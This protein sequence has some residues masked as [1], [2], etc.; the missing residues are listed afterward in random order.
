MCKGLINSSEI[1]QGCY[2][3]C[4]YGCW[5][6]PRLLIIWYRG[7]FLGS[8]KL[9]RDVDHKLPSSVKVKK[10]GDYSTPFYTPSR[11]GAVKTLPFYLTVGSNG[12]FCKHGTKNVYPNYQGCFNEPRR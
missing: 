12:G 8:E 5:A 7:H 2:A 10:C 6:L 3:K 4:P 11:L 1:G 9:G